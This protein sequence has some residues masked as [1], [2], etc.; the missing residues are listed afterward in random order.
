M[1]GATADRIY[2]IDYTEVPGIIQPLATT[3]RQVNP[4]GIFNYMG[5]LKLNPDSDFWMSDTQAPAIKVNISGER[6]NWLYSVRGSLN[7]E[8][9]TGPGQTGGF[10]TQWNDWET[11]WFG[12]NPSDETTQ[13]LPNKTNDQMSISANF[14][15]FKNIPSSKSIT[16]E[17]ITQ[18]K[19][20]Y[21]INK[22]VDYYARNIYI[23]LNAEGLRPSTKVYAFVDG[24]STP[25]TIYTVTPEATAGS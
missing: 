25:S 12:K 13:I 9:G 18:N 3:S 17:S 6:D 24:S 19:A 22:D 14:A 2:T 8:G 4:F 5:S 10:G 11:N 1:P 20:N 7:A 23:L 21:K 15:Q 16:P